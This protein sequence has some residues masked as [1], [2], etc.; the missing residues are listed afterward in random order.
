MSHAVAM[1]A[2]V[3]ASVLTYVLFPFRPS[4]GGNG[5]LFAAVLG[6]TFATL[7]TTMA[8]E[9]RTT[10]YDRIPAHITQWI[11]DRAETAYDQIRAFLGR[12]RK[13]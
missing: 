3:L 9:L 11:G 1:L 6:I 5:T 7:W 12:F 4:I 13:P 2:A 10:I 8:I